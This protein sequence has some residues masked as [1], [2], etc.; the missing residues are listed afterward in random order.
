M[1]PPTFTVTSF[2]ITCA[3]TAVSASDCVGFTFPGM[4]EEPGSFA[5]SR[6]SPSPARG[7]DPS[8]RMS[9]AIFIS[10]TA[11]VLSWPESSTCASCAA[12]DSNLFGAVTNGCP[13]SVATSAATRSAYSGCAFSPV[14]TA[15]PPRAS[16]RSRGSTP[17]TRAMPFS[18][19]FA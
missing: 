17:S 1:A 10:D 5:G 18:T 14:P 3:H 4:I 15:V 19:C 13:V 16:S 8:M 12:S 2:P 9:F 7:P 11:M 6:S